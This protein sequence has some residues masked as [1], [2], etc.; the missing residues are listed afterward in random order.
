MN[1]ILT[2]TLILFCLLVNPDYASITDNTMVTIETID[3]VYYDTN[4]NMYYAITETD[5][6]NEQWVIA[7]TRGKEN[8]LLA[9][10]LSIVLKRKKVEIQFNSY[11]D[12]VS[13][14]ILSNNREAV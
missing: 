3:Y 14:K 6:N 7:I 13:V 11:N 12:I 10:L 8:D 1:K 9:K 4:D 2:L 5:H